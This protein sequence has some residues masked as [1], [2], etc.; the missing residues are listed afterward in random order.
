MKSEYLLDDLAKDWDRAKVEFS[1]SLNSGHIDFHELDKLKATLKAL[2]IDYPNPFSDAFE[3]TIVVEKKELN[4]DSYRNDD[5]DENI[6]LAGKIIS[7]K[8]RLKN[9][10]DPELRRAAELSIKKLE[11]MAC[12]T[13]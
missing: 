8:N 6:L 3:E 1:K 7:A 10:S 2:F 4:K 12:S 11:S 5:S 13:E 9:L